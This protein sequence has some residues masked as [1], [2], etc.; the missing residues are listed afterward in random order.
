MPTKSAKS[1]PK[2]A[3]KKAAKKAAGKPPAKKAVSKK[4]AAKPA[5][6]DHTPVRVRMYRQGL[7][8]CFLVT[9]DPDGQAVHMLIDCGTLG[10][11]TTGNKMEDIVAHIRETTKNH[12][13]LMIATHEHQDHVSGF[14]TLKEEFQKITVDHVWM[15]WTEN[16]EDDLAK[17]LEKKKGDLGQAVGLAMQHLKAAHGEAGAAAMAAAMGDLLEFAVGP[18]GLNSL[19]AAEPAKTVDD[20]MT[21][22][23]T[24][25]KTPAGEKVQAVYHSPGGQALEP[26]WLP[27]F[28]F[29]V[30]GPPRDKARLKDMGQDGS[31]E[32]YGIADSLRAGAA[33]SASPLTRQDET[34]MPFDGRFRCSETDPRVSSS[35]Q[36]YF[37][38]DNTWRRVD[39]EWLYGASDLALQLD[40]LTNNTSLALAIERIS[41]GKVLLFPADAQEG[42]WLSWHEPEVPFTYVQDGTTHPTTAE[43]LLNKTVFYKVGHHASHNA[44]AKAKGLEMMIREDELVAFIPVD[45]KV[46]LTRSPKGQWKMPATKLY[47]RLLEKCQGRVA[48]SDIGWADDP[49]NAKEQ[50]VEATF[51][52]LA[53]PAEWAQ[54]EQSRKKAAAASVTI[55]DL[56][57]DYLLK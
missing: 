44:T 35:L 20:G 9:F 16:P 51:K 31:P 57:I 38:A 40:N 22:V 19:G 15:A 8:D 4:T 28:R 42:H 33:D 43:K 52:D 29:Y 25:Q 36:G 14:H 23:R 13:H 54:W 48:R 50:E 37:N 12:I 49:A 41:D 45:R 24:G 18:E 55:E 53:T 21:F 46:A 32:I 5:P 47:R 10:A 7:G 2:R 34:N 3:A 1:A 39:T 56:Y 11:V 6:A 26:A 17:V 27:G 30:L